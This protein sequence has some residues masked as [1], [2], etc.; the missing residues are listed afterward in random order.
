MWSNRTWMFCSICFSIVVSIA[1]S[2][3]LHGTDRF[4]SHYGIVSVRIIRSYEN[5]LLWARRGDQSTNRF[6]RG[7][8][9]SIWKRIRGLSFFLMENV[10][11]DINMYSHTLMQRKYPSNVLIQI[12]WLEFYLHPCSI[13]FWTT[14]TI[15]IYNFCRKDIKTRGRHNTNQ[16]A[17][18]ANQPIP[19][20]SLHSHVYYLPPLQGKTHITPRH[21]KFP[22]VS[23]G[24]FKLNWWPPRRSRRR[25]N[26]G[27]YGEFPHP[28]C[29]RGIGKTGIM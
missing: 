3:F 21:S 25:P 28:C 26:N 22:C 17:L 9:N 5:N 8:R 14:L 20:I 11:F 24:K 19:T 16:S 15:S 7:N 1:V 12:Y 18:L 27:G 4:V 29:H 2:Y 6:S 23:E 13:F 10:H